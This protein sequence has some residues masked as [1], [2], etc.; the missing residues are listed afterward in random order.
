MSLG[1]SKFDEGSQEQMTGSR[2]RAWRINMGNES[3]RRSMITYVGRN[4]NKIRQEVVPTLQQL[5]YETNTAIPPS[6][7]N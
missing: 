7:L 5:S 4:P 1:E 2:S 6:K 3:L